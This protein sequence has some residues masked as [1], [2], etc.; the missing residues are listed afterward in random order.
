MQCGR[1]DS[2]V[3]SRSTSRLPL[4]V[5]V[6]PLLHLGACAYVGANGL[7]WMP[8]IIADLPFSLLLM[9]FLMTVN[10]SQV[11]LVTLGTLWWLGL[12]WLA[13]RGW[14]RLQESRTR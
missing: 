2:P 8:I 13:W 12:S 14:H 1:V 5:Y 4:I 6:L 7:E 3:S 10:G 9:P 11:L